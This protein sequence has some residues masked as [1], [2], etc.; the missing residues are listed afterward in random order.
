M[1]NHFTFH[2][3]GQGLFY[4]GCLNHGEYTFVYDCGVKPKN[5]YLKNEINQFAK[6]HK[7]VDFVLLSHLHEDHFS[8]I[9]DLC[10]QCHVKKLYLPYLGHD[11]NVI[12][13][14]LANTLLTGDPSP[15]SFNAFYTVSSLYGLTDF[16]GNSQLFRGT[17]VEYWGR[18]DD[19]SERD[20]TGYIYQS[21]NFT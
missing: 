9:I 17:E 6:Y 19:D 20:K 14:I 15:A 3:V 5:S 16:E 8:G 4:S 21:Q 18:E 11:H 2:P 7:T 10:L 12:A 1:I 13:L